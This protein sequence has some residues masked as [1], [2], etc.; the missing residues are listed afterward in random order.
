[1]K[2]LI[3][4]F[5]ALG[6]VV[7][8][9]YILPGLHRKYN[10]PA[11]TWLTSPGSF[12]LLRFNPYISDIATPEFRLA[13]VCETK[14]D[15]VISLD[16]EAD[17]L[18]Y[19][20]GLKFRDLIGAYLQD[21]V[22]QYTA[23]AAAWF[24]MGLISRFGKEKADALKK[25]NKREHNQIFADMFGITINAPLFFNSPVIE[26][27]SARLFDRNCFNI[28][29]N[30][31]AGARWR[32]KQLS[33]PETISLIRILLSRSI[34]GKRT[35]VYLLGGREETV[36]HDG[37]RAAVRSDWLF[38]AG[39]DNSLLE[40]AAVIRGCDYVISSDSL[41][42]HLAIAQNIRNLSFFAPTSAE[43][44][45]TFGTGVKLAS[46]APDYCCYRQD[47]DTSTITAE[48]IVA[49]MK[50][51]VPVEPQA[52]APGERKGFSAHAE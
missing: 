17:I 6:D 13:R 40:F 30:S 7:R 3:I 51:S 18:K 47:A 19:I 14:F 5:G 4:K 39:N 37:I 42:L 43:E 16:D 49:L 8:T 41:A 29:L 20:D 32:S 24:D 25:E 22:A 26:E 28:G 33:L 52:P 45:G 23:S 31:G 34:Q 15:L 9:A 27:K 44:I 36:R 10:N 11:V 38:D 2:I 48:R 21:G 1:M 46:L 35:R 50:S 12:E